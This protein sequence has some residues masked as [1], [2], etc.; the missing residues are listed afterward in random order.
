[1]KVILLQD[2]ENLGKK[3]EIKEVADGYARNFLLP[4][5]LA[6]FADESS[7]RDLEEKKAVAAKEAEESLKVIQQQVA[8]LE[9]QEIEIG[10]KISEENKLYAAISEQKIANLLKE[11]GFDVLKSQVKLSEPIKTLGEYEAVIEY[12]HGLEAKIK[13]IVK[14]E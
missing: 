13:L 7:L 1:M 12:D 2:I 5:K 14:E 6:Q 3:H 10:A 8:E 9:G 4:N 11:R